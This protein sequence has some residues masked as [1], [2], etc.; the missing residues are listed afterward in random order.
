MLN[1]RGFWIS[2]PPINLCS[3][4]EEQ[5]QL[6]AQWRNL[7]ILEHHFPYFSGKQPEGAGVMHTSYFG[8]CDR[9]SLL[10]KTKL[11][12]FKQHMEAQTHSSP[13]ANPKQETLFR[14]LYVSY[15]P[16]VV[17]L[18]K[19]PHYSSWLTRRNCLIPRRALAQL[20]QALQRWRL[21]SKD[22]DV[23][24]RASP[25][26]SGCIAAQDE[27]SSLF[28]PP[29]PGGE[30]FLCWADTGKWNIPCPGQV[31]YLDLPM[32]AQLQKR[33]PFWCPASPGFVCAQSSAAP[34][35]SL[36]LFLLLLTAE[37]YFMRLMEYKAITECKGLRKYRKICLE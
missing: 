25:A 8:P 24:C 28:L 20:L 19:T 14:T 23:P 11:H 37:Y 16:A 13:K 21:S 4:F 3:C 5:P 36:L 1:L 35:G 10:N 29:L 31:S 9:D 17:L 32:F 12:G 27:H 7:K 34:R 22:Q 18:W 26:S 2:W 15:L 6:G 30:G 33:A